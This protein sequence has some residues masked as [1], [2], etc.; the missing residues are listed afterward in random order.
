MHYLCDPLQ[1]YSGDVQEYQVNP[2]AAPHALAKEP[3]FGVMA[4]KQSHTLVVSLVCMTSLPK[5]LLLND[6]THLLVP[7]QDNPQQSIATVTA[8]QQTWQCDLQALAVTIDER[9]QTRSKPFDKMN[10]RLMNS[11]VSV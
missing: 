4:S 11:A 1:T 6:W 10:P 7:K 2:E 8:V 5:P 9:N 3:K